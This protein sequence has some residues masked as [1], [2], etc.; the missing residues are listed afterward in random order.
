MFALE[1]DGHGGT[2]L[3]MDGY[4]QSYVAL[5]DPELLVFGYVQQLAA[6]LDTLPPGPLAV[7]HVGGAAMTLPRYVQRTRPGSPQIVL[8]PDTALTEAVREALPLP[9]GHRIRVRAQGG[10]EGIAGLRDASADLVVVDAFS[11]SQVPE[12][13]V[14]V[15]WFA[16][17]ARVLRPGGTV[18]MNAADQPDRRHAERLH[19]A[20]RHELPHTAAL[21]EADFWRRRR[22]GNVVLIG[23]DAPLPLEA[24][25]RR[26]AGLMF[27]S[28][29]LSGS[30]LV[31]ALGSPAPF[32]DHDARPS[33]AP[34]QGP[35]PWRLR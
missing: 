34:P 13:L 21:A 5:D 1:R 14:T 11:G 30:D 27:P 7:T 26:V 35:G 16:E 28:R 20:M 29:L 22:F 25:S 6:V 10:R 3:T 24:L 4:P 9:R 2:T 33:P 32:T 12:N 15:E 19:A 18:V 8:E 17:V 31:R 23:S